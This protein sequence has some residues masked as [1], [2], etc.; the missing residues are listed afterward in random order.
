MEIKIAQSVKDLEHLRNQTVGYDV[1]TLG[2]PREGYEPEKNLATIQIYDPKEDAT[3][4]VPLRTVNKDKNL[5]PDSEMKGLI[6][7]LNVVGHYLQFDL[8]RTQNEMGVAPH[9]VGDTYLVACM[10]QW[11]NKGLKSIAAGLIESSTAIQHITDVVDTTYPIAWDLSNPKQL[12]YMADD[13]WYAM[14][15]HQILEERGTIA[16]LGKAYKVDLFALPVFSDSR[17][18]GIGVDTQKYNK[19]M[20]DI[21][22]E[23]ADLEQDFHNKAGRP[24]K[25]GSSRD[26]QRLLF[27]DLG[28]P[29]TPVKTQTGAPSVNEE[30][31]RYLEDK[32]PCVPAL[33]ALKHKLSVQSGSKKMPT[34]LYDD[35]RLHPE[36]RQIGEDATSRVYTTKPSANQYP[37]ELRDCLIADEGHKLLYFDWSAAELYLSAYWAK[38][39][40][41]LKWYQEGDTIKK[42]ASRILN[43]EDVS[44]E[45]RAKVKVVIYSSLYGSEGAAAA[46]RLRVPQEE[47]EKIIADFFKAFPK[48]AE[49][50]TQIEKR[51]QET[52]Y[53]HTIIGRPRHL[54]KMRSEPGSRDYKHA[55]RQAFNTA[56]QSSVADMMKIATGRTTRYS[57]K[58][59][60]FVITVFDSMFL[61][62]PESMTNEDIEGMVAELSTFKDLKFKFKYSTGHT[63]RECQD[64]V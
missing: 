4:I 57:D 51:A 60:K 44:E 54:T 25:A 15:V 41:L 12:R 52:H 2:S 33:I 32:H 1:E 28:L 10:L 20:S 40:E 27:L 21:E 22:T 8:T 39:E 5:T 49:L 64:K 56:I 42:I 6:K 11:K 58:G 29:E 7:S 63:W 43:R 14:R 62:V 55:T 19:L 9:P 53:T 17:T 30:A 16:K 37:M 50:K 3:W 13:P 23:I 47:T 31:L 38:D 26:L 45:E 46:R 35:N 36:F 18:R 34:F 59:V 61:Q 48:I 24:A